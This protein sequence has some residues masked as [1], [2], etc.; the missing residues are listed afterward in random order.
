MTINETV[1]FFISGDR[2]YMEV[3]A[4][5]GTSGEKLDIMYGEVPGLSNHSLE[6]FR[7]ILTE[8]AQGT[9]SLLIPPMDYSSS[10]VPNSSLTAETPVTLVKLSND[11][12]PLLGTLTIKASDGTNAEFVVDDN[13]GMTL[14]FDGN[15]DGSVA[16]NGIG[17]DEVVS[18]DWDQLNFNI[19]DFTL[20]FKR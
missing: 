17:L 4:N 19:F 15:G 8:T 11:L 16:N 12:S 6:K 5:Q 7:I 9:K 14:Y 10:F 3:T 13:T 20:H 1:Q 2:T 18:V